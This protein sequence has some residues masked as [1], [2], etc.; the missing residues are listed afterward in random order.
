[1][2]LPVLQLGTRVLCSLPVNTFRAWPPQLCQA[3]LPLKSTVEMGACLNDSALFS[4]QTHFLLHCQRHNSNTCVLEMSK[5]KTVVPNT[6]FLP[7]PCP[8]STSSYPPASQYILHSFFLFSM[9][10][11]SCPLKVFWDVPHLWASSLFF[12]ALGPLYPLPL[13]VFSPTVV[14]NL[15]L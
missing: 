15:Q 5:N 3:Q 6:I 1:M 13:P 10:F 14:L 4:H 12:L 11:P 2:S 9:T 7:R 8:H